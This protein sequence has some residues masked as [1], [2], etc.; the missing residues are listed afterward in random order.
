LPFSLPVALPGARH[1]EADTTLNRYGYQAGTVAAPVL[2]DTSVKVI[3]PPDVVLAGMP[4]ADGL[5]KV[6]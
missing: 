6:Q 5:V 3:S 4:R 2:C 1:L